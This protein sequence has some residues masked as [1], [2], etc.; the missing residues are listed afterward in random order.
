MKKYDILTL[1]ESITK[2]RA[3]LFLVAILSLTLSNPSLA[4]ILLVCSDKTMSKHIPTALS[5]KEMIFTENIFIEVDEVNR[6][7]RFGLSLSDFKNNRRH[8]PNRASELQQYLNSRYENAEYRWTSKYESTELFFKFTNRY[9]WENAGRMFAQ[10]QFQI[11][12]L[13]GAYFIKKFKTYWDDLEE[14]WRKNKIYY[15]ATGFCEKYIPENR[16]F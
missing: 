14:K 11:N 4:S 15:V 13:T 10:E 2:M 16:K 5:N 3:T 9:T 7:I 8:D 12:R 1:H 6:S